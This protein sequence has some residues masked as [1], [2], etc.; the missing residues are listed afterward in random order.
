MFV[1]NC[2]LRRLVGFFLLFI[3]VILLICFLFGAALLFKRKT[4]VIGSFL[5]I[6]AII[7]SLFFGW[8][9]LKYRKTFM[10]IESGMLKNEV[11]GRMGQPDTV[12]DCMTTI[13][14]SSVYD[15]SRVPKECNEI[16][17]Y[18]SFFFPEAWEI[19]FNKKGEVMDAVFWTSP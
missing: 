12:T 17:W 8:Q 11:V 5:V 6:S 3:G 15:S 13:Y 19:K 16:S 10:Q 9:T 18:Y 2:L 7:I 4:R 1:G 14:G